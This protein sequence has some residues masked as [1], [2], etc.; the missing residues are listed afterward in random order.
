MNHKNPTI[1]YS[2]N[3][4]INTSELFALYKSVGWTGY[5]DHPEKMKKIL[6]GSL[7]YVSAWRDDQLVGL[8]RTVGDDA[9]I[10]YIQDI[11]VH[12]E[13]Q[14]MQIG[15]TLVKKVLDSYAHIRQII[16]LTDDTEK[17]KV[18]YVSLG[19]HSSEKLSSVAFIQM[20]WEA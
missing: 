7:H 13:Y 9:S 19:F 5:T 12:P 16:L 20:N 2:V 15:T 18:F 4:L 11:L 3:D 14:R 6:P 17:T 1:T 10:L 8:I